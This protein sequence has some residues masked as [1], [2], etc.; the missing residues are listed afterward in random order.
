MIAITAK[1]TFESYLNSLE[2][3]GA[4]ALGRDFTEEGKKVFNSDPKYP[5]C[6]DSRDWADSWKRACCNLSPELKRLT[7]AHF[8]IQHLRTEKIHR[9]VIATC[10]FAIGALAVTFNI[11]GLT[12]GLAL[13]GLA[14]TLA[15]VNWRHDDAPRIHAL[16]LEIMGDTT[17]NGLI[18]YIRSGYLH[19]YS[20][21]SLELPAG[22]S[23]K[24]LPDYAPLVKPGYTGDYDPKKTLMPSEAK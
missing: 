15:C 12:A 10:L 1:N 13:A 11:L 14:I 2:Y 16:W 18:N 22:A 17:H 4:Q 5:T 7:A 23:V 19:Q 3:Y 8:E 24:P 6:K 9:Y 21:D 20:P